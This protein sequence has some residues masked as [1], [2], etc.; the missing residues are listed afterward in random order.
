MTF[1]DRNII[2][3]MVNKCRDENVLIYNDALRFAILTQDTK[4]DVLFT[5]VKRKGCAV[6][7][8][9]RM[10]EDLVADLFGDFDDEMET[11][12]IPAGGENRKQF[13]QKELAKMRCKEKTPKNIITKNK[14]HL[15]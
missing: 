4:I 11:L 15:I 5:I 8:T 6:D 13:L 3:I 1:S 14:C 10:V 9:G 2:S 7:I 12:S